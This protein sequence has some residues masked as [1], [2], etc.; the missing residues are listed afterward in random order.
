MA[1]EE[2]RH[3]MFDFSGGIV[4]DKPIRIK[5]NE[6]LQA[7]NV[8][9]N[10]GGDFEKRKGTELLTS[11]GISVHPKDDIYG[12]MWTASDSG[13]TCWYCGSAFESTK[14]ALGAIIEVYYGA[15]SAAITAAQAAYDAWHAN[16]TS[17]GFV[18]NYTCDWANNCGGG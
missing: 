15:G 17:E 14:G 1:L 9:L 10:P 3:A 7:K 4:S 16:A 12:S 5:G 11:S 8:I 6:L 13:S 18:S 2:K